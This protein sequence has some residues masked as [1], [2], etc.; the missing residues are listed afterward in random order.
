MSGEE[1]VDLKHRGKISHKDPPLQC[2]C[3]SHNSFVNEEL[4]VRVD[5][6]LPVDTPPVGL[7]SSWGGGLRW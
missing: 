6:K 4:G 1:I 7:V 5:L 2:K 3:P